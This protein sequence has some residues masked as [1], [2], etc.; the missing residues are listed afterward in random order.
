MPTTPLMFVFQF[1]TGSI[2]SLL[3]LVNAVS[4]VRF[5]FQTGSIKSLLDFS[6][7]DFTQEFQFQTGSIK[8]HGFSVSKV[9]RL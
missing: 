4:A 2:K 9:A 7:E 5:Q 1:Q 6:E 3:Y 8:R